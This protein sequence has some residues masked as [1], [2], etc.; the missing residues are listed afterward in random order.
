MLPCQPIPILLLAAGLFQTAAAVTAHWAD[1][2]MPP[3]DAQAW[4]S[5]NWQRQDAL[6]VAKSAAT[7]EIIAGLRAVLLH[8]RAKGGSIWG[9]SYALWGI[10][11]QLSPPEPA[12]ATAKLV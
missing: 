3:E 8:N 6:A 1:A 9:A 12:A 7:N 4:S 2:G 11:T 10:A 5:P